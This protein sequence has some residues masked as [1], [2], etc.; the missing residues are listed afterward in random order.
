MVPAL[1]KRASDVIRVFTKGTEGVGVIGSICYGT[2]V[3][4]QEPC[5]W[6][7]AEATIL[8][9]PGVITVSM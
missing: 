9:Y 5:C 2:L 1:G 3:K 6:N 4:A 8:H 7:W